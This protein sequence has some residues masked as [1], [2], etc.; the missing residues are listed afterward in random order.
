MSSKQDGQMWFIW[1]NEH[2]AWWKPDSLGYT[3]EKRKAGR[4]T[5]DEAL[6]ICRSANIRE[7]NEPEESMVPTSWLED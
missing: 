2:K 7:P 6:D 3:T 4:Y 1:S 5:Y